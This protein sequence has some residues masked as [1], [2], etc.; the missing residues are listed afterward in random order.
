MTTLLAPTAGSAPGTG[1]A[2]MTHGPDVIRVLDG[3]LMSVPRFE[4]DRPVKARVLAGLRVAHAVETTVY[5]DLE[6]VL[7]THVPPGPAEAAELAG[8]FADALRYLL[9]TQPEVPAEVRQRAR[10]LSALPSTADG[11]LRRLALVVLDL[12]ELAGDED[13]D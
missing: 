3:S 7:G 11:Y 13:D 8:R 12:L 10:V 6:D 9:V 1:A 5:D 2:V 4:C